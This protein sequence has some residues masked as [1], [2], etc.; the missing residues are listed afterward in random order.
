MRF[1]PAATVVALWLV[2]TTAMFAEDIIISPGVSVGPGQSTSL[3]V[4]LANPAPRVVYVA[5]ASSDTSIASVNPS[6]IIFLQGATTPTAVPQVTGVGFG[7]ASIIAS[8]YGF[9][10]ASQTVQVNASLSFGPSS[11][12]FAQG[13]SQILFVTLSSQ[14]PTA[15][16]ITVTSD[17]PGVVSVPPSVTI[18]ANGT[19]AHLTAVGV[20]GGNTVIHATGGPN[21][22][23]AAVNVTVLAPAAITLQ[24]VSLNLG[25]SA[26]FPLSLGTPAPPGGV[27]VALTTSDPTLVGISSATAFVPAGAS[28][29][30][31]LPQVN[32]INIGAAT[33]TA[34]APGYATASEIVPV[35]AT[36]T[37]SPQNLTLASG[38][39][40]VV[41]LRLSAA[42]PPNGFLATLSSDNPGVADLQHN[43][44]FFPDGSSF[45]SNAIV[46][47][48]IGPGT[49]VIHASAAPF[50][51][52][53][54]MNVTVLLPGSITLQTNPSLGVTQSMPFPIQLG[55]PAQP[56]GVNVTLSSSDQTRVIVSPGVVFIAAGTT[57]PATQP[58]ITA[59][60]LGTATV[61]ASAPGYAPASTL[62]TVTGAAPAS[63]KATGGSPQ[64]TLINTPFPSPLS[65][66]VTDSSGNPVSGVTVTFRAPASG[67]SGV[68]A[69]GQSTV[70]ATTN[71]AG[72][73]TSAP[74]T[75]NGTLGSYTVSALVAGVPL[76]AVFSLTNATVTVGPIILPG[77]VSLAP[78]Q[79]VPFPVSLG[80]AAPMGGVTITLMSSDSSKISIAPSSVFIPAG[81][82]VPATQPQITGV[83]FGSVTINASAP[84]FASASQTAQVTGT[85]NLSPS[86]STITG[87]G[88]ENL[89]LTLSVPAPVGGYMI[90]VTS[91][92]TGVATVPANVTFAA[93]GT[94]VAVPVTGVS[95]GSVTITASSGTPSLP[96]ATANVT[97][98]PAADI[99]VASGVTVGPGQ[100]AQLPV[101]LNAPATR[102]LFVTMS[103]SDTSKVLVNPAN[104]IVLEGATTPTQQ[105]QVT[106]VDFGSATVSA[107]A[108][109]LT[110]DS[111]TVRVTALLSFGAP[112]V[113]ITKGS[114]QM[115]FLSLSSTA[116]TDQVIT[117]TSGDLTVVTVPQTVTIPAN[118][119]LATVM[120]SGVG[121]GSTVVRAV[122]G[123]NIT[124]ATLTANV[125]APATIILP[126]VNL[127]F[128]Q[129]VDFPVSLGTPAPT[130]GT[131]VTLASSDSSLV[132]VS[133]SSISIPGGST[134][135]IVQPQVSGVNIGSATITATAPGYAT[136]ARVI[137]VGAT[138][139]FSPQNLT[140]AA[141][142]MQIVLL[143][144][145][146]AAPPNGFFATLTSDNPAVAQVQQTVGFFPDGSSV[147]TNSVVINGISPGTTVIHASAPPFIPDTTLNVT[148]MGAAVAAPASQ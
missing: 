69:G 61:S 59:L 11:Q 132:N 68:F 55:T 63:V 93:N 29:P 109:G 46:I 17:N 89:T 141:G 129:T 119:S 80:V 96:N 42:A 48:A 4:T 105:P 125:V 24:R 66:T 36:L 86:N 10:S 5:L 76:P 131:T 28:A 74:F 120:L 87:T 108:F 90:S 34:S 110:G 21:I 113:T 60:S 135:P 22:A 54:T 45:A 1:I 143:R 79:S 57:T 124:S 26:A 134:T 71:A 38:S 72:V 115:V 111:E 98:K 56:G 19:F 102:T 139:T 100:S 43:V 130:G 85:L 146:T 73:A 53:T 51:P 39:S 44:G 7:S 101:S 52:D 77:S 94:T 78:N 2:G 18:P 118:N 147:A 32:G 49:T 140:L 91:S 62:V 83:T 31:P 37:F 123:Q 126:S 8:S 27:S 138:L 114:S 92:N 16:T 20:S 82:T 97:V 58:Q 9:A 142:S 23:P 88:T 95:A 67:P 121:S 12:T 13:S 133:P 99:L 104:I 117:L 81:A 33:I 14:A 35:D 144:L 116:P 75:A 6:N 40:Q 122:G 47:N 50:I 106:G 127:S 64:S 137:P 103:S 145:S 30:S 136:A 3:P 70:T 41:M 25:Q 112:T 128:G 15:Q 148:V 84:G 107:S 65:A